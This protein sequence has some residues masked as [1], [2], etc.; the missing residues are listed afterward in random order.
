MTSGGC[1]VAVGS[2]ASGPRFT[3]GYGILGPAKCAIDHLVAQL[4][5]ELAPQGIR[6]NCVATSTVEAEWVRTHPKGEKLRAKLI[7]QTPAGRTGKE[8]DV[9]SAVAMMCS[10]DA[11]WIVG[12][13][14]TADG[15]L[16]LVL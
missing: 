11:G 3:P 10:P 13:K 2:I 12:Q 15:G 14:I 4:G 6:V 8:E 7:R 9:A 5:C 1:I 16:A